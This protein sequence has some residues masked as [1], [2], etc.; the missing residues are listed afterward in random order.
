MVYFNCPYK[1]FQ[2]SRTN[3]IIPERK[4]M[5]KE[6]KSLTQGRTATECPVETRIPPL[7]A[8]FQSC[9]TR[10]LPFTFSPHPICHLG[11]HL[12]SSANERMLNKLQN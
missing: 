5:F 12:T 6:M 3:I 11:N 7:R 8:E 10:H 1:S 4:L 2:V 9:L